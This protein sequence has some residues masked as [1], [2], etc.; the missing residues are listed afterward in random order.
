VSKTAPNETTD[1]DAP[2]RPPPAHVRGGWF[3]GSTII[4]IPIHS[5]ADSPP[6]SLPSLLC[7][8]SRPCPSRLVQRRPWHHL[9]R[10]AVAV[11]GTGRACASGIKAT[12]V[13]CNRGVGYFPRQV[14][15]YAFV[16]PVGRWAPACLLVETGGKR[17]RPFFADECVPE[18]ASAESCFHGLWVTMSHSHQSYT[19][20]AGITEGLNE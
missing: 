3:V 17:M 9:P 16:L 20:K 13:Y 19:L 7:L 5:R 15:P 10:D 11:P 2:L 1:D 14:F 12:E 6:P 8:C 18:Y 4:P